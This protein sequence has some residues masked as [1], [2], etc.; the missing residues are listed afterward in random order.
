MSGSGYDLKL[1][2][3]PEFFFSPGTRTGPENFTRAHAPVR[4]GSGYP[5]GLLY[6]ILKQITINMVSVDMDW[7]EKHK[8]QIELAKID[9]RIDLSSDHC[10]YPQNQ[11]SDTMTTQ[12]SAIYRRERNEG[13]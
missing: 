7:I 2:P 6:S 4:S 11:T 10:V 12:L 9:V 5:A 1:I 3:E 13:V 8:Y